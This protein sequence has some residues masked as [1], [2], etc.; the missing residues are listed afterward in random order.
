MIIPSPLPLALPT[1]LTRLDGPRPFQLDD[2][3]AETPG[4]GGWA[5]TRGGRVMIHVGLCASPA[6]IQV[7][8]RAPTDH[9]PPF[10]RNEGPF[11]PLA[12]H[13][14]HWTGHGHDKHGV[15]RSVPSDPRA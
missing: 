3:G 9:H 14:A 6:S 13:S 8:L 1:L 7:K 10:C 4:P 12:R 11:F 15:L 2:S 5:G